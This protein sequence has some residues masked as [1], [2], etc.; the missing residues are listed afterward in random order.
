MA[1]QITLEK[2]ITEIAG[3]GTHKLQVWVSEYEDIDPNVFV[4]WSKNP[5]Y[6]A[7]DTEADDKEEYAN[8]AS[9]SCLQEYPIDYPDQ[10]L[11]PFYRKTYLDLTFRSV[12]LLNQGMQGIEDDVFSLLEMLNY[13]DANEE[14]SLVRITRSVIEEQYIP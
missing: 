9:V 13:L 14:Q 11:P 7:D 10:I 6:D 3:E 12:D 8:V 4:W 5:V 2:Q 1:R